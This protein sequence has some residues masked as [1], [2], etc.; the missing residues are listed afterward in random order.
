MLY[1][2]GFAH[3]LCFTQEYEGDYKWMLYGH[4]DTFFFVDGALDLLQDFD[5]SLPY[6]ITGM[7]ICLS[8]IWSISQSEE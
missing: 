1:M 7:V 5:P 4:D 6:I 8:C 3:T 2:S